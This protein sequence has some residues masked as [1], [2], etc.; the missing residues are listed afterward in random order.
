MSKL[1]QIE[2]TS[3]LNWDKKVLKAELKQ[4]TKRIVELQR[5]MHAQSKYSLLVIIQGMDA[6]GKDGVVREVFK[7][8]HPGAIDVKSF[9]KPTD[10]EFAHDFLWRVHQEVPAKGMIKVFNR[11]HYE[12]IL[13]P[14]VKGYYGK[15]EIERRYAQI[16]AFEKHLQENGTFIVKFYLHVS[17]EE[18]LKRLEERINNP[19]KHWKHK[20]G[21]WETRD[22]WD[23][24]MEVYE[25]LFEQCDEPSW[26]IIPADNNAE[27]AYWMAKKVLEVL[28]SM[29]LE[30]PE[31]VS[32]R[33]P[34]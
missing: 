28:E 30:W 16:N 17:K 6:S 32:E 10:L 11:S 33:F 1:N 25:T 13:V 8:I 4:L 3:K 7:R 19:K 24:Y 22:N 34:K 15:A 5:Q 20:D 18:Q 21:D 9:K 29:D 2:T 31:L 23:S 27:K 12:D 26:N 14:S